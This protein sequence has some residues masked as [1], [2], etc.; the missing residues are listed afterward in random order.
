MYNN[1][2]LTKI[3]IDIMRKMTFLFAMILC[4]TS[5]FAQTQY[6]LVIGVDKYNPPPGTPLTGKTR[7]DF[8]DLA[9]CRNDAMA[10]KSII[11]TR[12][13]FA[14]NNITELYDEK[15]TRDGIM[16]SLKGL[17]AKAQKGNIVFIYYAGHGSQQKNSLSK[18]GDQM[19]ESM[20]PSDTWKEG[21]GDIRDK[22][23]A[24]IYNAFL[25]KGVKLTVILDCCHSGS[26]SR[27]PIFGTERKRYIAANNYDAKDGSN[28]AAP[29]LRETGDF[30]LISAAQDFESAVEQLD[31]QNMPHGAFTLALLGA[32]QQQSVN[33]SALNIFKGAHAILKSN[34]KKQEPV[35]AGSPARQNQTLFGLGKGKLSDKTLIPAKTVKKGQL[36]IAGGF[37][38]GLYPEH[39]LTMVGNPNVIVKVATVTGI[40]SALCTVIKGNIANIKPGTMFEVSNWVSSQAP[41]LTLYIPETGFNDE[42]V[43]GL[44]KLNSQLKS[45]NKIKKWTNNL[46]ENDPSVSLFFNGS[47]L[48]ANVNGDK[49]VEVKE[50][51]LA[52]ITATVTAKD[53]V[54]FNV[55][56]SAT[57]VNALKT[58]FA[59]N[60][61]LKIVTEP[62]TANY[63]L[64]GTTDENGLPAYGLM[65]T[66]VSSRDSLEAM[67]LQTKSFSLKGAG[68]EAVADSLL[69]Y[70]MRLSKIKGW[71][72]L[73]GPSDAKGNAFPFHLEI[74]ND[75]T[76]EKVKSGSY[77]VGDA[78]TVHLVADEGYNSYNVAPKYIYVFGIDKNGGMYLFYPGESMG[79]V[80][81]KI[82]STDATD[83]ELFSYDVAEPVGT[84]NLYLLA[85]TEPIQGYAHLFNQEDVRDIGGGKS[86]DNPLANL[87]NMGNA[88]GTRS[89]KK[90]PATWNVKRTSIK[91]TH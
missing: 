33:A 57:L 47:K 3:H 2:F 38:E 20:V 39:E 62:S 79:S 46:Q 1:L 55:P 23:Q 70:S 67:P 63:I 24:A 8:P 43:T 27:G 86:V 7:S 17:L 60:K 16:N 37:A 73:S 19:D 88:E 77:K 44:A 58:K 81:N 74:V 9:G 59:Q 78:V 13:G 61:S 48:M 18:E 30:L 84:D 80:E 68:Y 83:I 85:T 52:G 14:Q 10:I 26:M 21:V 91:T 56:A 22:E 45:S 28:P 35:I 31:E 50:P 36:E 71:M 49:L 76:K 87:L 90:T 65:K 32:M 75:K 54:F 15:A 29:E 12:Y 51:T 64:Y 5:V 11:Q 72:N 4:T 66:Q 40:S 42:K 34:G 69:E 41:L 89:F 6:A 82:P 25:D 53:T